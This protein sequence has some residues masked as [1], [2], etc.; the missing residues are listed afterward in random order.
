MIMKARRWYTINVTFILIKLL[1]YTLYIQ[2]QGGIEGKNHL[3]KKKKKS[4]KYII[5]GSI[6][7]IGTELERDRGYGYLTRPDNIE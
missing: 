5:N 3:L 1:A 4:H 6:Q 7:R 2:E